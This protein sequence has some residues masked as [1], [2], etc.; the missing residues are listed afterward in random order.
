VTCWHCC[1][2]CSSRNRLIYTWILRLLGRFPVL[3]KSF[4]FSP[5]L[6][7]RSV[8]EFTYRKFVTHFDNLLT[9]VDEQQTWRGRGRQVNRPRLL[10]SDVR[11]GWETSSEIVPVA[12]RNRHLRSRLSAQST[13]HCGPATFAGNFRRY[14]GA[15][16]ERIFHR[17]IEPAAGRR[18]FGD[19]SG[20]HKTGARALI[21]A[22]SVA[23]HLLAARKY[24]RRY[25]RR[26]VGRSVRF[27]W[28]SSTTWVV[29]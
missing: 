16:D 3:K 14:C 20:A 15:Q 9:V 23:R 25:A 10:Q 26:A 11:S 17:P 27:G 7:I 12:D 18:V 24:G 2:I 19:W 21:G 6:A 22:P 1:R 13:G 29:L 28:W 5:V 4:S 8:F